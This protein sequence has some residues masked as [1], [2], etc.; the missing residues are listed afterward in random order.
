MIH[1]ST[2]G[3]VHKPT[4]MTGMHIQVGADLELGIQQVETL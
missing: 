3:W 4:V 2:A 1:V